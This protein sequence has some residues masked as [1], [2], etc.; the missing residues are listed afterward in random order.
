VAVDIADLLIARPVITASWAAKRF[1]V[2]FPAANNGIAKLV[3]LGLLR[4][5]T[6]RQYGR[7]F[8]AEQVLRI[9]ER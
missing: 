4:E 2:T 3:E 6:G 1:G 7:L 8:A 9:L 5:M